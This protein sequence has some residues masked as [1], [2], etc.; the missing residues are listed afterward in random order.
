MLAQVL[1]GRVTQGVVRRHIS[2]II[3]MRNASHSVIQGGS[4]R[5]HNE[6]KCRGYGKLRK[7]R[8]EGDG[9]FEGLANK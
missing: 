3:I 1:V 6:D 9:V 4:R 2:C 7:R 5:N 8:R